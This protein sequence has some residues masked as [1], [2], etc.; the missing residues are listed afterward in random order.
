MVVDLVKTRSDAMRTMAIAL[1]ILLSAAIAQAST[2]E[3]DAGG[4]AP[5]AMTLSPKVIQLAGSFTNSPGKLADKYLS[6]QAG[7]RY[8]IGGSEPRVKYFKSRMKKI[9]RCCEARQ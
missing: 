6:G 4:A 8:G 9:P 1:S 7:G 5:T 2:T 3:R